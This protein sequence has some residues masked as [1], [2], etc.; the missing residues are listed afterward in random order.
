MQ[1]KSIIIILILPLNEVF[2]L[3]HIIFYK[4]YSQYIIMKYAALQNYIGGQFVNASSERTMDV[5]SPLDGNLLSTVP[6]TLVNFLYFL[7]QTLFVLYQR[8]LL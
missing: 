4:I 1:L 5:I 3:F 6:M 7:S 2:L 8:Q